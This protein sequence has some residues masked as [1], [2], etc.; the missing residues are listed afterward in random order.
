MKKLHPVILDGVIRV[1]GR[2]ERANVEFDL[3]HPILLPNNC[4]L[5]ELVI[6]QYHCE[7]GHFGTSDAGP[8]YNTWQSNFG[9]VGLE[10][11][12]QT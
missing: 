3:K 9:L 10:N 5:T 8:K 1:G 4:H 11:F 12:Y 6:R 2:L 7:V